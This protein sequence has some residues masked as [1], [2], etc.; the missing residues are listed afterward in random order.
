MLTYLK[1]K[2]TCLQLFLCIYYIYIY[3]ERERIIKE[4]IELNHSIFLYKETYLSTYPPI[5]RQSIC[6]K[7]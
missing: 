2:R 6:R 3:R 1:G 5:E 4:Y 7:C